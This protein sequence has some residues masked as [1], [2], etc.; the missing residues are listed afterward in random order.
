VLAAALA[1]GGRILEIGTGVGVGTRWLV[2]GVAG[3][4]D[5]E[6]VSVKVNSSVAR[7]AQDYPWLSFVRL[8]T[9]SIFELSDASATFKGVPPGPI[10]EGFMALDPPDR[11]LVAILSA[12]AVGYSRLTAQDEAGAVRAIALQREVLSAG[13]ERYGGRVVDAVGDNLLAEFPSVVKAVQ[14][15]IEAQSE[16]AV[17]NA[18]LPPD[19]QLELRIGIHLGDVIVDGPRIA[20][21]GVNVAARI[22]ERATPGGVT[23]SGA[24][25]E[26]IQ[27]KLA[28][29]WEDLGEQWLKNLP[30]PVRVYR[31]GGASSQGPPAEYRSAHHLPRLRTSFIGRE[32][33]LAELDAAL[34]ATRLL[35]L[36]GMGGAGKSRLA[37]ELATRAEAKFPGGVRFAELAPLTAPE[38]VVPAVAAAAGVLGFVGQGPARPLAPE[39][40]LVRFL[41]ERRA[42]LVFDNCEHLVDAAARLADLLLERC[43]G[44]VILATSR[45]PLGIRGEQVWPVPP[46]AADAARLFGERARAVRPDFRAAEHAD[47]IRAI[48][49]RLDGIPLAIELAAA[50]VAHLSPLQI[51]ERLEDRLKL[52]TSRDRVRETRHQALRA[53][54]D[55]SHDLLSE[56]ERVCLRR[57]SVFVNGCSLEA[58]EHVCGDAP[59][60]PGDVLDVL[61][62]L[63][64]RSLAVVD[65]AG[66]VARYQLLETVRQYAA[67]RLDEAGETAHLRDRHSD[68]EL[69]LAQRLLPYG[70]SVETYFIPEYDAFA[71]E[72][73]NFAA[74][75]ARCLERGDAAAALELASRTVGLFVLT[76]RREEA[77]ERIEK[78]LALLQESL[79]PVRLAGI[80]A[81]CIIDTISGRFARAFELAET[82]A[83]EARAAGAP[84]WIPWA[85]I[86]QAISAQVT[87]E[88]E[89]AG[90]LQRAIEQAQT[91]GLE[92]A[93]IDATALLGRSRIL[94]GRYAE[95]ARLL[96]SALERCDTT[97]RNESRLLIYSACRALAAVLDG[98]I[99]GARRHAARAARVKLPAEI[100][101]RTWFATVTHPALALTR[102]AT[103]DAAGAGAVLLEAVAFQRESRLPLV[104]ASLLA[105]FGGVLFLLG[106]HE[107]AARLLGAARSAREG[108]WR[109]QEGG[110]TYVHFT[111]RVRQA[112]PGD[113][114]A[115]A[116]AAGRALSVSAAYDEGIAALRELAAT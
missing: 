61:G 29:D 69:D 25:Y 62:G 20:G 65:E 80:R 47:V 114:A 41:G 22:Q 16:L 36:T 40:E 97:A 27:G 83:T 57:L 53:T 58:A 38:Q 115:R 79:P 2:A 86:Y 102:A 94:E 71:R 116:R 91:L 4:V 31:T 109:T 46:L 10:Q 32:R 113:V 106:Q 110:A 7:V 50:R 82:L 77:R 51:A 73:P 93:E 92:S 30:R 112:L 74:A 54:L 105:G 84:E 26:Q 89:P 99:E 66:G 75:I 103:G 90:L 35:T 101:R 81:L 96:D 72:V 8:R 60:D 108:A 12:D 76:G 44:I 107:R 52:L 17:H 49:A 19:A 48:C 70:Y 24:G 88:A 68:W 15:A 56:P 14:C 39:D 9:G 33:E 55:W 6:V 78:A 111:R 11:K 64:R 45:E 18:G 87:G 13:V 59:L 21:D 34:A 95:A 63:V 98:D 100:G 85:L 67:E 37:V 42:L 23:I 104:D 28:L 1:A 43:P 3:R 5:V